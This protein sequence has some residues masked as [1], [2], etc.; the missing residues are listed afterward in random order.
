MRLQDGAAGSPIRP[1]SDQ[2]QSARQRQEAVDEEVEQVDEDVLVEEVE[3]ERAERGGGLA[4][5]E[6]QQQRPVADDVG[7][8]DAGRCPVITTM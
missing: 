3:A 1:A 6:H 2:S 7:L 8:G 4:G 5:G